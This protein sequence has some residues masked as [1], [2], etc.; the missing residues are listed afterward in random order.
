MEWKRNRMEFWDLSCRISTLEFCEV[1]INSTW[2]HSIKFHPILWNSTFHLKVPTSALRLSTYFTTR[3]KFQWTHV[4]LHKYTK[5][6]LP[7]QFFILNFH[8]NRP[9]FAQFSQKTNYASFSS[10]IP[11]YSDHR[12]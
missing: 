10:K 9:F 5:K 4:F 2:N 1:F 7:N 6:V 12:F 8:R 11:Y 3:C